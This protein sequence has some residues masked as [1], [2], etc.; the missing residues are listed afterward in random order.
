MGGRHGFKMEFTARRQHMCVSPE[1][2]P[3]NKEQFYQI[4]MGKG[5]NHCQQ[6]THQAA[7]RVCAYS[8]FKTGTWH[9][10]GSS[11]PPPGIVPRV[12]QNKAP[13]KQ[14]YSN[15]QPP[16]A[17]PC[18]QSFIFCRAQRPRAPTQRSLLHAFQAQAPPGQ[19][20]RTQAAPPPPRAAAPT[21]SCLPGHHIE[22]SHAT[23]AMAHAKWRILSSA[24]SSTIIKAI[25][26]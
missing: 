11:Q 5:A 10:S 7:S 22:K 16:T 24:F 9:S 13:A 1:R 18:K 25:P 2:L 3:P 4:L 17:I 19:A 15:A 12:K 26:G 14:V 20:Q 6:L 21:R 8:I 23:W